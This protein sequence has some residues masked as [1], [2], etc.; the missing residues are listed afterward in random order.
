VLF[1]T[2]DVGGVFPLGGTR[3]L[4][5]CLEV[6]VMAALAPYIPAKDGLCAA[7]ATNFSALITANP[8]YYGLTAADA[9]NIS[10]V[11]SAFTAQ[12]ALCTSAATKT[13]HVVS[14]KNAARVEMLAVVRPYAQQISLNAG[15]APG[16][17]ISLG[18]NPRTSTPSP[19]TP[20]ASAPTLS[21]VSAG[22]LSLVLRYGAGLTAPTSKSKPYGVTAIEICGMVSAVAV[23]DPTLLPMLVAATKCPLTLVRPASEGGK[24]IYL[25]A[26]WR[27]RTGGY[28]PWSPIINF[29]VSAVSV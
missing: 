23:T 25:A 7:W 24:Q 19:I 21:V 29:T 13:A 17:K 5:F 8:G 15:V 12:Y 20:P 28:S 11:V 16:D 4:A 22:N 14:L 1:G 2:A 26:R 27:T 6:L 9:L 18:L 10:A 3:A